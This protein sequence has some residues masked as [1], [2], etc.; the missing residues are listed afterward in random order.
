MKTILVLFLV[1]VAINSTRW[2]ELE[3]Y[4]FDDYIIEFAK[5]Y[6]VGSDEYN[7]RKAIF[8]DKL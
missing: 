1:I 6:T 3:T 8:E 7:T 5:S 2:F 4:T